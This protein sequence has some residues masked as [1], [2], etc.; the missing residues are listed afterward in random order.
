[1]PQ[2][3]AGC[4]RSRAPANEPDCWSPYPSTGLVTTLCK[5][6]AYHVMI[7]KKRSAVATGHA[8]LGKGNAR[9]P[10]VTAATMSQRILNT[11]TLA[12][13]GGGRV[14]H[15]PRLCAVPFARYAEAVAVQRSAGRERVA[16]LPLNWIKSSR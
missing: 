14:L 6:A 2:I 12:S 13:P 5:C 16:F 7:S 8:R 15:A 1:M 11:V 10:Q 9:A 3:R 4:R